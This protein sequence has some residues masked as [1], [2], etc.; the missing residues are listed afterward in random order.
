MSLLQSIFFH[1]FRSLVVT[2]IQCDQSIG[3]LY[4]LRSVCIT[5]VFLQGDGEHNVVMMAPEESPYGKECDPKDA[6]E[7]RQ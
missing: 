5:V 4:V 2:R 3:V 1:G 6:P 7:V